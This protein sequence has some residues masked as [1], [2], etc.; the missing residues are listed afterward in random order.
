[1]FTDTYVAPSHVGFVAP[2]QVAEEGCNLCRQ[3]RIITNQFRLVPKSGSHL[4]HYRY[5]LTPVARNLQEERLVLESVWQ[6]LE[7]N[8]GAIVVR[9][10]NHL[11]STTA[12]PQSEL[13][14]VGA[15]P[16]GEQFEV[17]VKMLRTGHLTEGGDSDVVPRHVVTRLAAA[18]AGTMRYQ[19]LGRRYFSQF[20]LAGP[21][22]CGSSPGSWQ[23]L[24]LIHI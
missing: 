19:K 4:Y 23:P 13:I 2:G 21:G 14:L 9:C 15:L 22:G 18:A 17:L 5:S 20:N 12:P 1:M 8:L 11:F 16:S 10:P 24:S 3:V 7:R 6:E